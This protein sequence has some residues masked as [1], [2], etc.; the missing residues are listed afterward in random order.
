VPSHSYQSSYDKERKM[1]GC[2]AYAS[3]KLAAGPLF[4]GFV[5]G[6][7]IGDDNNTIRSDASND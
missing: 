7:V 2:T 1:F 3:L 6:L 4:D 5:A